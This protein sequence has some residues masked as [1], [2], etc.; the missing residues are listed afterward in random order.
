MHIVTITRK[1][2]FDA[3]HRVLGHEGKCKHLHGH[4]YVAELTVKGPQLD[5]I[6]RV[7]DFSVLKSEVGGWIDNNW[8]HNFICHPEDPLLHLREP[9]HYQKDRAEEFV[10]DNIFAG[11]APFIMPA[12]HPNPTAENMSYVLYEQAKSILMEHG[13][14]VIKIRLYETPNCWADHHEEF[15]NPH[16]GM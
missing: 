2:E 14:A 7:I 15:A 5:T 6:G 13:I 10:Y 1:L 16:P 9:T 3:G 8:D 4:R 12:S 11:K